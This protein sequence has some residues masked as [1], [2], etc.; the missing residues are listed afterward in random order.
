HYYL[1][2]YWHYYLAAYWAKAL[3][4][5]SV[6]SELAAEFST[7]AEKLAE[8]EEVIVSEL[9]NAQGVAGDLGGYY[10]LVDAQAAALMRPSATLNAFIDA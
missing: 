4:T 7:I 10:A 9:N 3:S 8:N 6:D 1:A 2:A 5:Q